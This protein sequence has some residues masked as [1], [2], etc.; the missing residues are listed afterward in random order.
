M[1]RHRRIRRT[2]ARV[3]LILWVFLEKVAMVG[4]SDEGFLTDEE[5]LREVDSDSRRSQDG[6][7]WWL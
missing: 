1:E 2:N 7:R 6:W 4:G 3:L 5:G